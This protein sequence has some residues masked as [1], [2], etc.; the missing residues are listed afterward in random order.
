MCRNQKRISAT[1]NRYHRGSR[2]PISRPPIPLPSPHRLARARTPLLMVAPSTC[3]QGPCSPL[4][5]HLKV[6]A[7]AVVQQ[8]MRKHAR[9]RVYVVLR[10]NEVCRFAR[11]VFLASFSSLR[12]PRFVFLASFSSLRFPR[13]VCSPLVSLFSILPS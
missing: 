10:P 4:L 11:F 3:P 6:K 9:C 13:F 7:I 8:L 1:Q 2:T 12:F 5:P